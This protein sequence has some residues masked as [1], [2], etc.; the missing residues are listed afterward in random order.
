MRP[1][2]IAVLLSACVTA[3]LA[4]TTQPKPAQ[5]EKQDQEQGQDQQTAAA[6]PMTLQQA[7]QMLDAQKDG[8]KALIYTPTNQPAN[9]VP[10]KIKDW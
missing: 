5:G 8:E 2:L 9:P 4:E 6:T 7:Q 1:L 10:R 3:S